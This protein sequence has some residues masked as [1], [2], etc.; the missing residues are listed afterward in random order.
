MPIRNLD[1]TLT[2]VELAH[3]LRKLNED[4]DSPFISRKHMLDSLT[5][6][7]RNSSAFLRWL[8]IPLPAGSLTDKASSKNNIEANKLANLARY[9]NTIRIYQD[10]ISVYRQNCHSEQYASSIEGKEVALLREFRARL[11]SVTTNLRVPAYQVHPMSTFC[12]ETEKSKND[13]LFD[14]RTEKRILASILSSLKTRV[15]TKRERLH[16]QLMDSF[17]HTV[18]SVACLHKPLSEY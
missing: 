11:D 2:I 1:R 5:L 14:S 9:Y 8:R 17:Q 16:L 6:W 12:I 3:I 15:E 13:S 4:T 7:N 10:R 18:P